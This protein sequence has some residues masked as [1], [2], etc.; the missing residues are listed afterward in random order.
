MKK[1]LNNLP[2]IVAFFLAAIIT[3]PA[4]ECYTPLEWIPKNYVSNLD[5]NKNFVDDAIDKMEA[6]TVINAILCL[7][8]CATEYD[9]ERLTALVE[10][11]GG[12]LGYRS[13]YLS[14]IIVNN[15]VVEIAE[16]F[17]RDERVAMVELE[18]TFEPTLDV[19]MGAARIRTSTDYLGANIEDAFPGIDGTG[20]NIAIMDTGVDNEF[21]GG[22]DHESFPLG[23]FINGYDAF[24]NI[25]TDPDDQWGHGTH[26]AG[27]ALGTGGASGTYRGAAPGA[28]L[29][30]IQIFKPGFITTDAIV[31]LA[32]D[33]VILYRTAWGIDVLNMSF[34]KS[35]TNS[36]GTDAISQMV[37]RVVRE[38]VIAVAAAGN[39]GP[40]NFIGPPAAA[41]FAITVASADDM[42][43]VNRTDD[44]ISPFSS[45]GPRANDGDGITED[46]QKPDVTAYGSN[47]HSAEYNTVNNYVDLSGT[48]MATPQVAGLAALILQAN[49]G[50][51]PLSVK[52]LIERTAE[53][54]GPAGWDVNFGHGIINGYA[55]LDEVQTYL[56]TD[57]SF[58]VYCDR[59]G[60]PVW[61][62]SPDV[63]PSISYVEEG[64]TNA[65]VVVVRNTGP[66]IAY[67]VKVRV[68]IFNFSNSRS[69]YDI[70]M[71]N[72][73]VMAPGT[74]TFTCPWIPSANGAIP[75]TVHACLK[76][77]IIYPND[78]DP[79]NNCAQHNV[80][81]VRTHSPAVFTMTVVNPT[82]DEAVM[83]IV[84]DPSEEE[85]R[86][87]G[88]R[89]NVK[90]EDRRFVMGPNECPRTVTIEMEAENAKENEQMPVTI[91]VRRNLNGQ[92]FQVLGGVQMIGENGNGTPRPPDRAVF[93]GMR[94]VA[95]GSA[96][97]RST[98][99]ELRV[100]DLRSE[101]SDEPGGVTS[102]MGRADFWRGTLADFE[103]ATLNNGNYI[104]FTPRGRVNGNDG[105]VVS[106]L[107]VTDNG[108]SAVFSVNFQTPSLN[109]LTVQVYDDGNLVGTD[110]NT[111]GVFAM[112]SQPLQNMRITPFRQDDNGVYGEISFGANTQIQ[113]LGVSTSTVISGD[114]IVVRSGSMPS[115]PDYV[116]QVDIIAQAPAGFS[117]ALT[118][119]EGGLYNR[120]FRSLGNPVLEWNNTDGSL[121]ASRVTSR[122]AVGTR[123]S[124]PG[125]QSYDLNWTMTS[126]DDVPTGAYLSLTG[127][128]NLDN[129][130]MNANLG[131]V[132]VLRTPDAAQISADI[133]Q[134]G[135]G[136]YY[137]VV[138][139]GGNPV[140]STSGLDA[141]I[142]AVSSWPSGGGVSVD[143]ETGGAPAFRLYWQDGGT[144]TFT[145]GA[146]VDGDEL[147]II[148]EDVISTVQGV[149]EVGA[150]AVGLDALQIINEQA[151]GLVTTSVDKPAP[152]A[153]PFHLH[154]NFPNPFSE[155]TV[156]RFDLFTAAY[157]ELEVYN[158]LGEKV[159]DVYSRELTAGTHEVEWK[160]R[161]AS[162]TLTSGTYIYRLKVRPLNSGHTFEINRQMI[163]LE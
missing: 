87:K 34:G 58:D 42:G 47:I 57:I 91:T 154:Q 5:R 101:N 102:L 84:T 52:E 134:N 147:R 115:L 124:V 145:D 21:T 97:L 77:Y 112:A 50:M 95:I 143:E 31:L 63:A 117:F 98:P 44:M 94:Q 82:G 27:I 89:L 68:G 126:I 24:L 118:S 76:A 32:L 14:V 111:N 56:Q 6:G 128:G 70:C 19:S 90:D 81:I 7:N 163:I 106:E 26:V 48:S 114:Q 39:D 17:G 148:P 152:Y 37:N 59:P 123:V 105:S 4:Q 73:A 132:S 125:L 108:N 99:A 66:N 67:N 156:F 88:W 40:W 54:R 11:A 22:I 78:T 30:D 72:I 136:S 8:G 20:V 61:W 33:K 133:L 13:P 158:L 96:R 55:A 49:P 83:E 137:I 60:S 135:V 43:T 10:A 41:D 127:R 64:V 155:N 74:Y 151:S 129:G 25:V 18:R 119:E 113:I 93:D 107:T 160:R 131:A 130:N 2:A 162:T 121:L 161:T 149:T 142:G 46:E 9:I 159:A 104:S 85:I 1:L 15:I 100:S 69:D 79:T 144:F 16:Q 92:E 109:V 35:F 146:V 45:R 140:Y 157:V 36:D 75:S 51:D 3:V 65:I 29:I 53:D 71:H 116:S 120:P 138:Y 12:E 150:Y 141:N 62:A 153:L 139:S 28:G 103:T 122:S 110:I 80:D 38:G 86:A 23:K